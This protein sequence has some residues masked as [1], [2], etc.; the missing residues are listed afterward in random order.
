[1]NGRDADVT[2]TPY[3]HYRLEHETTNEHEFRKLASGPSNR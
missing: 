3:V 2:A 1:M